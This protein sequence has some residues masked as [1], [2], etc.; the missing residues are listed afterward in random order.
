MEIF[1]PDVSR[2]INVLKV[3]I[4]STISAGAIAWWIWI[5]YSCLDQLQS[6]QISFIN[7][8]VESFRSLITTLV[9]LSLIA[10]L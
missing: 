9:I 2:S 4:V 8:L 6:N 1:G 10:F 3:I 7:L 5:V